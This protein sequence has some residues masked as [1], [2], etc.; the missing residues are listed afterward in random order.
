MLSDAIKVCESIK[1]S[2]R[3]T[4]PSLYMRLSLRNSARAVSDHMKKKIQIQS[5]P[6]TTS[7]GNRKGPL[8]DLY[9]VHNKAKHTA[10]QCRVL[11]KLRRPPTAIQG[12]QINR[13]PPPDCGAFQTTRA[14]IFPNNFC[15]SDEVPDCEVP[16]A[17]TDVPPQAGEIKEQ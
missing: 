9:P 3:T 8:D 5:R 4:V 15:D 13:T 11:K 2:R 16:M 6:I 17:S 14:V 10:C 1:L 12:R 7:C